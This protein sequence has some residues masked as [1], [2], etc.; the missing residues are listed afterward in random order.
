[1]ECEPIRLFVSIAAI[2]NAQ[3]DV[4]E[5]AKSH[6][7]LLQRAPRDFR[8]DGTRRISHLPSPFQLYVNPV[9]ITVVRWVFDSYTAAKTRHDGSA[10]SSETGG[11]S[12]LSDEV[13][14]LGSPSDL[15]AS[16]PFAAVTPRKKRYSSFH[17]G[18]I[19]PQ[20][21]QV[22][23]VNYCMQFVRLSDEE[24]DIEP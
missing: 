3:F 13:D 20:P 2:K 16:M 19:F 7:Y 14:R 24:T 17:H 4:F 11:L 8:C 23:F 10:N 6:N 12:S 9:D 15:R 5:L 21:T 22:E 1:M 18:K